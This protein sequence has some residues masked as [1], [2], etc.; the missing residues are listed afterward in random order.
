MEETIQIKV[1]H[2]NKTSYSE[3]GLSESEA[4]QK[5]P[6][7]GK[8]IRGPIPLEWISR[9]ANLPGK[10]LAVWTM[11]WFL[12]GVN[13]SRPFKPEKWLLEMFGV[14]RGAFDNGLDALESAGLISVERRIGKRPIITLVKGSPKITPTGV[15]M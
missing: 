6:K 15:L 8:Y 9:A 12:D 5:R 14:G 10:A 1:F 7:T 2:W 13:Q 11:L 4:S 3:T